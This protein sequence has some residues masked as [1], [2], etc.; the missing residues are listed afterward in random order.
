MKATTQEKK[1]LNLG[2]CPNCHSTSLSFRS[3]NIKCNDC[4]LE[5][6]IGGTNDDAERHIPL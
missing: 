4:G 5:Y 2:V 3:I 6:E 1:M